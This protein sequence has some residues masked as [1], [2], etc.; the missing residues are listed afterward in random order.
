MTLLNYLN[1]IICSGSTRRRTGSNLTRKITVNMYMTLDGYG[2]FPKYPGSDVPSK[3]PVRVSPIC[4]SNIMIRWTR[5]CTV[6]G[7]TKVTLLSIPNQQ[8]RHQIRTTCSS[9][10]DS[11]ADVRRSSSLTF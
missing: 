8:G 11:Y 5:S 2:E 4:G 3:E 10:H 6:G 9:S 7:P 1:G